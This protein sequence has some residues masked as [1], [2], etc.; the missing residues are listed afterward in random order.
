MKFLVDMPLSPDLAR[1]LGAQGHD[2][3]HAVDLGLQRAPDS[4]IIARTRQEGRTVVTAD[5]DYPPVLALAQAN[6]PSL[7]LFRHG[8]WSEAEVIERLSGVLAG[9]SEA[10]IA[11]SILVVDRDRVRRRQLPIDP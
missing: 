2:A 9:L 1:W 3:V 8:N 5:L 11:H 4:A 10:D 6:E 7:I